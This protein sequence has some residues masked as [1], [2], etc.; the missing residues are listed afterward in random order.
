MFLIYFCNHNP[1][2]K[3]PSES[4]DARTWRQWSPGKSLL[5]SH[6]TVIGG[7]SHCKG[8][9]RLGSGDIT[10]WQDPCAANNPK[11]KELMV[12][13]LSSVYN[14]H[15]PD[16]KR[17]FSAELFT[18]TKRKF[19]TAACCPRRLQENSS[20]FVIIRGYI[21]LYSFSP[22]LFKMNSKFI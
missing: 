7:N 9:L 4:G 1:K 21:V 15:S 11:K 5:R 2:V 3:I 22:Y 8:N 6:E 14:L 18:G 20:W 13:E 16:W 19:I 17:W 10:W 12:V